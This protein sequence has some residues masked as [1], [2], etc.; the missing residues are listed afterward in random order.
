MVTGLTTKTQET[1]A[2]CKYRSCGM[3]S[4][5]AWVHDE[6][7]VVIL[8]RKPMYP[9]ENRSIDPA[10]RELIE[11]RAYEI[12]VQRN[13]GPGSDIEDWL[14]AERELLGRSSENQNPSST[15]TEHT[16]MHN[17]AP[18]SSEN[19]VSRNQRAKATKAGA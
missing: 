10:D 14:Q 18:V 15:D 7:E 3:A 19:T 8:W 17:V 6:K 2:P 4:L 5:Q 16:A 13:G 9:S 11:M 1:N 12:Y